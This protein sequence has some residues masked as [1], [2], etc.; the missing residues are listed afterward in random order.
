[1]TSRETVQQTGG[2]G[3]IIMVQL[4]VHPALLSQ[5][6]LLSAQP[7]GRGEAHTGRQLSLKT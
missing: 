3:D 4:T 2:V 5:E 1:M 6:V 7:C